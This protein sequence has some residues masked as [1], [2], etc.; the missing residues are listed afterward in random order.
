[1]ATKKSRTVHVSLGADTPSLADAAWFEVG[2]NGRLDV[3][4]IIHEG[5]TTLT[6]APAGT[7]VGTWRMYTAG[8][9]Y[10]NDDA[11]T[12]V[13]ILAAESGVNSLADLV[14]NGNNLVNAVANFIDVPGTRCKFVYQRGS[15]G[16]GDYATLIVTGS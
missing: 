16:T 15:G 10:A 12:P 8:A 7:P 5:N 11:V 2:E 3:Q 9:E 1:M 6:G 14:P 13:R 4:C